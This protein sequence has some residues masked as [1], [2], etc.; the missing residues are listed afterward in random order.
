MSWM[1]NRKVHPFRRRGIRFKGLRVS[2]FALALWCLLPASIAAWPAHAAGL[3]LRGAPPLASFAPDIDVSPQNFA[4]AQDA[5]SIVYVGNSDGVLVFDG[6]RWTLV[7]LP[8]G[9]LVRSLA[10][11]G[12]QRVYVGGYEQLGYLQRDFYGREV[13]HD[14]WPQFAALMNGETLA[15]VWELLV[16]PQGIFFR[17]VRHVLWYEPS[18]GAVRVWRH[19]GRFGAIRQFHGAPLLQFR[20][21]GLRRYVDGD[22]QPLPETQSLR[23]LLYELVPLPDGGLLTLGI[24]GRWL[25]YDGESLR[26]YPMPPGFPAASSFDKAI[27]LADGTLAFAGDGGWVHVLDPATQQ[28]RRFSVDRGAV[29]ALIPADDGGLFALTDLAVIH[30]GWPSAWTVLGE[31]EGISG[32]VYQIRS[33]ADRWFALTRDGVQEASPSP[34]GPG[35]HFQKH[36]W[37]DH[38]A[39]D[40][41][42][43]DAGHALLAES[44][45]LKLV[46][47]N[48]S[49][50]IGPPAY[51]PRRLWR[52]RF[53]EHYI[54]VGTEFGLGILAGQG[55]EWSQ[56][57][58]H[59][60]ERP[61]LVSELVETGPLEVWLGTE[62]GGA[63]RLRFS[64][65]RSS[66]LEVRTFGSEDG[67]FYGQHRTAQPVM[68]RDGRLLVST[69]AG[70]FAWNGQRFE[71]LSLDGL[72][73]LR[74]PEEWLQL[75]EGTD[76]S[77]TAW[78]QRR[79][80]RQRQPG[81]PWTVEPIAD[82]VRGGLSSASVQADGGLLFGMTDAILQCEPGNTPQTPAAKA[83]Q[84]VVRELERI[85]PD[86][87]H[88]PLPLDQPTRLVKGDFGLRFRVALPD[89]RNAQARRYQ[90]QMLGVQKVMG[91]WTPSTRYS[92][93]QMEAGRY[94]FRLRARDSLGAISE[95]P[96][97]AFEILPPWYATWWARL[98]WALLALVAVGLAVVAA[99]A[100]RMRRL[101]A[102]K[103]ELEQLIGERTRELAT[104]NERLH[105]LAHIDGLTD[106]PNRRR[107]DEYLNEV[108]AACA[109]SGAPLSVLLIDLDNF[110]RHNDTIG[111]LAADEM[112]KTVGR[113][114]SACLR[115]PNDLVARYGGDE[116]VVV[117]PDT[118]AEAA[119]ELGEVMRREVELHGGGAT[120]SVG[121]G[122]RRPRPEEPIYTVLHEA[123][124]ALYRSKRGGRNRVS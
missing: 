18:S 88:T 71:P 9:D 80:L 121:A 108:W 102:E 40:L 83:P 42:P 54:Y 6:E 49:R 47:G 124:E 37:T 34:L 100:L 64:Q 27:A 28:T 26:P 21:E 112:L 32:T 74:E 107:L 53:D 24:D 52:S 72:A 87:S 81:Q 67:L 96:A 5:D 115:G 98:L 62:R 39:W 70:F 94:E 119:R 57:L 84:V 23:E 29:S 55:I 122:C 7:K 82:L 38:E 19:P 15:D 103:T 101:N 45:T 79:L 75:V 8:N 73:E 56:R 63:L 69:S 117:L 76:G 118:Q 77:R 16:S 110:K 36:D 58:P 14:L 97:L 92:Y 4:L 78:S 43:L 11:D 1:R 91:D 66:I 25:R 106:I 113:V 95:S 114:L 17:G 30:I 13:Y 44:Y 35:L 41:L 33:W 111:H 46:S 99:T 116:F 68:L 61:L 22:W 86:G 10:W 48:E 65:D 90:T 89:Y 50:T 51:Y 12:Q 2:A 60:S 104:A 123:D 59:H 31:H 120:I 20:G 3:E 85:E 93:S 105:E 109:C